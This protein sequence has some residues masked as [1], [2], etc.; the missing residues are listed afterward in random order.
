RDL[1]YQSARDLL[2]DLKRLQRDVSGS[3]SVPAMSGSF[4]AASAPAPASGS[5]L[6]PWMGIGA[7]A[8]V[9][10]LAGL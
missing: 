3:E 2:A 4:A 8:V 10:A 6:K 9:V 5:R 1:R 7:A